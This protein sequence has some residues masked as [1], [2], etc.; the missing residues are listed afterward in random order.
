MIFEEPL[1]CSE[2]E[3][4]PI[5]SLFYYHLEGYCTKNLKPTSMRRFHGPIKNTVFGALR[6]VNKSHEDKQVSGNR[7]RKSNIFFFAI[8]W[9]YKKIFFRE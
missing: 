9:C 3:C 4:I 6:G 5:V 1:L 7:R 2:G 8:G